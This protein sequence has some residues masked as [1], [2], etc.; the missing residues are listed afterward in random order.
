MSHI[1]NIAVSIFR[2]AEMLI[3]CVRKLGWLYWETISTTSL[4]NSSNTDE[5]HLLTRSKTID[6]QRKEYSI[7]SSLRSQEI[8]LNDYFKIHEKSVFA[9]KI[10]EGLFHFKRKKIIFICLHKCL[11][12]W[13]NP[14]IVDL[15]LV[16]NEQVQRYSCPCT[17]LIRQYAM[18]TYGET[19]L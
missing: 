18:K 3:G 2:D 12:V 5:G 10:N 17:Q 4:T 19:E 11:H 8:M 1:M 9:V 14:L 6:I 16:S 7:Y 13:N 15:Q